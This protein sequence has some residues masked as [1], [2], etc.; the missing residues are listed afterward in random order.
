MLSLI[1]A[2]DENR[3]IGYKNDMPWHLPKDLK[4]FKEITTNHTIIMGRKTFESIGRP[5]PNRKNVVLT[6][7]SSFASP[8][9]EVISDFKTVL[10]WNDQI[11]DEEFIIIG[12]GELYKLALPYIDRM[13]ITKIYESFQGDTFFPSFDE[14]EWMITKRKKGRTDE[15]NPYAYEFFQYERRI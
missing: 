12:G 10:Q 15:K 3:V 2:M 9:V 11:P 14:K 7:Q 4:H 1:V 6:R 13:Y 8:N 5:L